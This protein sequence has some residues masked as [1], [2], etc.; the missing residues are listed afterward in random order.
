MRHLFLF[1]AANGAAH[2]VWVTAPTPAQA[3]ATFNALYPPTR[4]QLW[5]TA[6]QP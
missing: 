4:A 3:L 1:W 2:R 5:A 6:P